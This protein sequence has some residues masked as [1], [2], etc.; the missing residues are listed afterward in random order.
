MIISNSI[1]QV[2]RFHCL[3]AMI[4]SV[5]NWNVGLDLVDL[6]VNVNTSFADRNPYVLETL[7]GNQ[8]RQRK[9]S[10]IMMSIEILN[11]AEYSLGGK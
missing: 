2:R 6:Q 7:I 11:T 4:K 8:I 10:I 1:P 9:K 3:K 5:T